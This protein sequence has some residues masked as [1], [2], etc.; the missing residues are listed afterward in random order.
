MG[1]NAVLGWP[2]GIRPTSKK[3]RHLC[4]AVASSCRHVI[5]SDQSP[6]FLVG[7]VELVAVCKYTDIFIYFS[8]FTYCWRLFFG[9]FFYYITNFYF[10]RIS[11]FLAFVCF[12]FSSVQAL[13]IVRLLLRLKCLSTKRIKTNREL[14]N[15]AIFVLVSTYTTIALPVGRLARVMTPVSPSKRPVISVHLLQKTR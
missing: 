10:D 5:T 11:I 2:Q 7:H 8:A 12:E 4:L 15:A 6:Y 1:L 9:Y 3:K 14:R 13:Y